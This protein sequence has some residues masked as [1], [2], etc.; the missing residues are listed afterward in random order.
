MSYEQTL[1]L[2]GA[3]MDER[4]PRRINVLETL[5][6]FAA[7]WQ[8]GHRTPQGCFKEFTRDELLALDR[9]RQRER[10]SVYSSEHSSAPALGTSY[11][12]VLRV[13][14]HE[15]DDVGARYVM[16]DQ[17]DDGFLVTYQYRNA[18]QDTRWQKHMA[19]LQA[20]EQDAL[21]RQAQARRRVK[22]GLAARLG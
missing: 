11:E 3:W 7:Q 1:R 18:G 5:E 14:G 16:L 4:H 13:L 2:I 17:L 22:V 9:K 12:N 21:M 19:I 6:G 15:L 20:K 10:K 8:W